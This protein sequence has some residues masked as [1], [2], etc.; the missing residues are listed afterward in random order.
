[1]AV[2]VITSFNSCGR[3]SI[4]QRRGEPWNPPEIILSL[5]KASSGVLRPQG[6]ILALVD[7]REKPLHSVQTR[8][9]FCVLPERCHPFILQSFIKAALWHGPSFSHV[10]FYSG[11]LQQYICNLYRFIM[12]LGDNREKIMRFSKITQNSDSLN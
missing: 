10:R 11:S 1:M 12:Y 7:T 6:S 9:A 8:W 5:P 2:A 3:E 4:S